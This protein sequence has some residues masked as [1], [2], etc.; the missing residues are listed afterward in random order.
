MA[1]NKSRPLPENTKCTLIFPNRWHHSA[2]DQWNRAILPGRAVVSHNS[3]RALTLSSSS[4]TFAIH[5]VTL[6][7]LIQKVRGHV[8]LRAILGLG[9]SKARPY[10][11]FRSYFDR[12]LTFVQCFRVNVSVC[13][14]LGDGQLSQID[15]KFGACTCVLEESSRFST[16]LCLQHA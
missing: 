16:P 9:R 8:D 12:N 3:G 4:L 10:G 2:R 1:F 15:G 5:P 14:A 13:F 11:R 7:Q 6:P